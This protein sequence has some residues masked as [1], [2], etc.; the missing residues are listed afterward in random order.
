MKDKDRRVIAHLMLGCTPYAASELEGCSL[1]YASE[2]KKKL[3]GLVKANVELNLKPSISYEFTPSETLELA[4]AAGFFDGEGC[5][6]WR[7]CK[8]TRNNR[9][10]EYGS[11]SLQIAQVHRE[12]LDRFAAAVGAGKV[13]GPY[14]PKGTRRQA[15]YSLHIIGEKGVHAFYK[16]RNFLSHIKIA[17]GEA[18]CAKFY[19]QASRPRLINQHVRERVLA[20]MAS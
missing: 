5:V 17:D 4:W 19:E 10:R 1:W 3:D 2:L 6:R 9:T 15:H 14:Q 20:E 13:Y 7:T 18:A 16:M 8:E 11:F 12:P